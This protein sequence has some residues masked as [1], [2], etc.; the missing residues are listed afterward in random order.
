MAVV[1]AVMVVV[2]PAVAAVIMLAVLVS[3]DGGRML[4][5]RVLPL[6]VVERPSLSDCASLITHQLWLWMFVQH[7]A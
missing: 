6:M 5:V 7:T 3:K 4:G 2:A 1:V